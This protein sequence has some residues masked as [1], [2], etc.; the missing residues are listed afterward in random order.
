M[1]LDDIGTSR[2]GPEGISNAMDPKP[3]SSSSLILSPDI[4]S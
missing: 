4:A 3:R 1:I 2:I